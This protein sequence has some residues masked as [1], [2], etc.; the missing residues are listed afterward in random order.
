[1]PAR[2][3]PPPTHGSRALGRAEAFR[4]SPAVHHQA[5]RFVVNGGVVAMLHVAM[6]L[7][8]AGPLGLALQLAIP[9][10]YVL[11]LAINYLS[12]R[13]FVFAHT[14][15]FAHRTGAQVFRY[16]GVAAAQYALI[17]GAT[18][19]LPGPLGLPAKV[20]YVAAA[21]TTPVLSFAALRAF[22]FH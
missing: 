6:G 7:A 18:A 16:L 9:V 8:L 17:A 22:V 19:V 1:M 4:R 14:A 2:P 5:L 3:E 10:A 15:Q 11:S 13:A 12:S 21:L 20:V